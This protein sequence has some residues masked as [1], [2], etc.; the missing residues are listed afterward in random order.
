[1][2]RRT[3]AYVYVYHVKKNKEAVFSLDGFNHTHAREIFT[4]QQ[5]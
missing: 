5:G 2:V 1:M 3:C 4:F